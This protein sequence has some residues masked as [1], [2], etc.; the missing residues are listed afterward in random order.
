[1]N[2]LEKFKAAVDK[3]SFKQYDEFFTAN[4]FMGEA[5]EFANARK[6]LQYMKDIPSVRKSLADKDYKENSVDEAGDVLFFFFQWLEKA[7]ITP[8][9]AMEHQIKKLNDKSLAIGKTWRK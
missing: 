5:G 8:E 3:H 7:G 1:M 6:K 4:A 9:Q 2:I